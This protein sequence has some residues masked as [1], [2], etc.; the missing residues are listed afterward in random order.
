[1]TS[2]SEQKTAIDELLNEDC[3]EGYYETM[4]VMYEAWVGSDHSSGTSADQRSIV[5]SRFK[6]LR[7]FLFRLQKEKIKKKPKTK[8][9]WLG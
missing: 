7:R 9:I 4:S 8:K 2:P 3:P 6:A 1:M 5:L